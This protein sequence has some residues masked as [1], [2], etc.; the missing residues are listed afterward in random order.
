M[1]TATAVPDTSAA[2]AFLQDYA[3]KELLRLAVVG[4]VDDGKSTLIGRLLFE[5]GGLFEDHVRAVKRASAGGE[6][7]FSLFTDGLKAEREQ[8][9]TIDVAYRYFTSPR[10]KIIIADTPG[11][12][13]YTR[14]MATGASTADAAV[15]LV[16]ARLGVLPQTLRHAS[17]ASLLGIPYLAVA[18]NKM[19]LVGYDP[20]VF[21]EL[22][23]QVRFVARSLGFKQLRCFPVS[24]T[25]G[26]NITSPSDNT[27]WNTAGTLLEWLESLPHQES[28]ARAPFRFP[29]QYVL[30]PN[31]DYRGFAGQVTSGTVRVG[32]PVV[33]LPSGRTS[34]VRAIDTFDGPL[35]EA[36][37]PKAVTIRLTDEVDVSRGDI[38]AHPDSAP[39]V[40]TAVR[41]N[42]VWLSDVPL[43]PGQSFLLK[44][45]SRYVPAVVDAV[46][47]KKNLDDLTNEP[48][49]GLNPN[50]IGLV[51]LTLRRPLVAD[52]YSNNRHTGGGGTGGGWR[53]PVGPVGTRPHCPPRT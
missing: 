34:R 9:I 30:R 2:R 28:R 31:L 35:D 19:D 48:A 13:Q 7:D 23:E 53:R 37:P 38:L 44:H 27:P 26:D 15:I 36:G 8:G 45:A 25:R 29:V 49:Q 20:L 6:I 24:A 17:I 5:T 43:A 16:D 4:S 32:D 22:S 50:D 42:L 14:N 3:G 51:K 52:A 11:H 47:W 12:T 46:E 41:A 39:Q 21:K 10:R 33:V 1:V 18:I 40:F